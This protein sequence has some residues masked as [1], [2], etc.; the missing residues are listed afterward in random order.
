MIWHKQSKT[1]NNIHPHTHTKIDA[2]NRKKLTKHTGFFGKF[3]TTKQR[4]WWWKIVSRIDRNDAYGNDDDHQQKMN[5]WKISILFFCFFFCLFMHLIFVH[6]DD[7]DDDGNI[8]I[9]QL[10]IWSESN[11]MEWT[12][13][14]RILI[15]C[16][17]F[18]LFKIY[19][20]C[21]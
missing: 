5:E 11:G 4:W 6:R 16:F 13:T 1:K 3:E 14:K 20:D 10:E 8:N 12:Q 7:H 18:V 15:T 21:V 9:F 2:K 19:T 17:V